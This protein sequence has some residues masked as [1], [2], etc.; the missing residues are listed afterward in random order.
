M[1][2][3]TK[4]ELAEFDRQVL[5][6]RRSGLT[7]DDIGN[8][9]DDSGTNAHRAFQRAIKRIPAQSVEEFRILHNQRLEQIYLLCWQKAKSSDGAGPQFAKQAL[10]ALKQ[11]ADLNG[12]N[13]PEIVKQEL[14]GKDGGPI[15]TKSEL[16]AEY[17]GRLTQEERNQLRAIAERQI[18]LQKENIH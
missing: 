12:L 6:L 13:A 17:L 15:E 10:E 14:T 7:F 18:K 16:T 3:R 8:R 5:V 2:R 4:E 1:T 11:I 9:L